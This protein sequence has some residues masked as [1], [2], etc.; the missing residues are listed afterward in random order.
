M[1][2]SKAQFVK[3][4]LALP[5][6]R[7]KQY[8]GKT[9]ITVGGKFLACWRDDERAIVVKTPSMDE[10]DALLEMDPQTYF[11]TP[12]YRDG[13]VIL[14][15]GKALAPREL[16]TVLER[17]WQATASRRLVEKSKRTA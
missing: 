4:A 12:V 1:P 2:V 17:R 8:P 14:I 15:R 13:A 16:K 3:T 11:I 7:E 6:T 5:G 9:Y 10:R